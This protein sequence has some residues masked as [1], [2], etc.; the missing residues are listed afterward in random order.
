M[1]HIIKNFFEKLTFQL[2]AGERTPGWDSSKNKKPAKNAKDYIRKL[3]R[4][5]DAKRR[6]T[7][8]VKQNKLC[9]WSEADRKIVDERVKD[10]VGPARW[11]KSSMVRK[12]MTLCIY[13][14]V[15]TNA[16]SIISIQKRI[17]HT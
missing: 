15:Y 14:Y 6:W 9:I 17:V 10:L 13:S 2:F 3:Q 16:S 8:A 12:T 1:M 7:K 11:I 5:I 4:H